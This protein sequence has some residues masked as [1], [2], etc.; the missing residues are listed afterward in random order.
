MNRKIRILFYLNSIIIILIMYLHEAANFFS[1]YALIGILFVYIW[2]NTRYL[3]NELKKQEALQENLKLEKYLS[4]LIVESVPAGIVIIKP[5][6]VIAYVNESVG[7]ILGSTKTVNLNILEFNTVRECGLDKL[8][9]DAFVGATRELRN[10]AYTSYTSHEKKV[11]NCLIKPFRY[12]NDFMKYDAILIIDDV[13]YERYLDKK[14]KD[15]YLSMFKSFVKFIDAKDSYTGQH[16]QNVSKYIDEMLKQMH[17][18]EKTTHDIKTAATLHDI[19]KIGVSDAILNKPGKLTKDEYDKMKKHPVIGSDLLNE[20]EDY[21][22]IS[23]IIRYHHER[24]DGK[25]YPEGLK[26]DN[27]PLGSQMIAI[28]D[29]YDAI[30]SNRVY[31]NAMS[32]KKAIQILS[33]EKWAQF[34]GELVD[35][36]I[37]IIQ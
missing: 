36:F 27:I 9:K 2:S 3:H 22:E 1:H 25:G 10:L 14:M 18:D 26:G 37:K 33:D 7:K 11:I 28:A 17:L 8:I 19:G 24:W 12:N 32:K 21:L 35:I 20:I 29:T 23:S 4:N 31:R 15:Q 6:G 5:D 34:N 16:S 13:T 30:T